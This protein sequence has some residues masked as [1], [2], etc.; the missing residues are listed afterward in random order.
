MQGIRVKLAGSWRQLEDTGGFGPLSL[1][2]QER[3]VMRFIQ[4][5]VRGK[6]SFEFQ[7]SGSTAEPKVIGFD[8]NQ[9]IASA[10]LTQRAL[11]LQPGWNALVCLDARLIAGA[12]MIVRSL[13]TGMNIVVQ[14]PSANPLR[15]LSDPIE[16]ASLVPYQVTALLE[17]DGVK[18]GLIK[19]MIV[20]G[21]PLPDT[22]IEKLQHVSCEVYA[23]Y[24]STE[25]I[26]HVALQKVNGPDRQEFFHILP[27]IEAKTDDRKCLIVAAPHFGT[28][29]TNDIVELV[30]GKKFKWLGRYDNV[31]NTG[32]VK[33]NVGKIEMVVLDILKEAGINNRMF[34]GGIPDQKLGEQVTLFI[35][36]APL[37]ANIE[38]GIRKK[39]P[40]RL[41]KFEVPRTI[42][43]V[44]SFHETASQKIDRRGTIGMT[45]SLS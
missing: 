7:T 1:N 42:R 40:E 6:Q 10:Q 39:M 32:G 36:C 19:M 4:E 26:S 33:V 21:A 9:L 29:V 8:R 35:E 11:R 28:V 5:W 15:D 37:D 23:T 22:T 30:D 17:E 31:I 12:M 24:A 25:T 43:Y 16:F 34:I 44:P 41:D 45:L 20:G 14:S 3:N 13:V 38:E 27:G 2:E 18:L